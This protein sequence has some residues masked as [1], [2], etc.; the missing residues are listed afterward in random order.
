MTSWSGYNPI[1]STPCWQCSKYV[2]ATFLVAQLQCLLCPAT[3]LAATNRIGRH[4]HH[5]VTTNNPW[6]PSTNKY[7]IT[8]LECKAIVFVFRAARWQRKKGQC[9]CSSAQKI[10]KMKYNYL[11]SLIQ[12]ILK[13]WPSPNQAQTDRIISKTVQ[14]IQEHVTD[15]DKVM[16]ISMCRHSSIVI[17]LCGMLDCDKAWWRC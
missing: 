11:H 9:G 4:S 3:E 5:V 7:H 16:K 1:I 8:M 10:N 12:N 15:L 13:W 6:S 14:S 2:T 17:T